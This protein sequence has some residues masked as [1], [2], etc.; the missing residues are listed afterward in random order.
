MKLFLFFATLACA[1]FISTSAPPRMPT[2]RPVRTPAGA[3]P[4]EAA[5]LPTATARGLRIPVGKGACNTSTGLTGRAGTGGTVPTAGDRAGG[6]S[7]VPTGTGSRPLSTPSPI[8]T[9]RP[10]CPRVRGISAT[11]TRPIIPMSAPARA[12]GGRCRRSNLLFPRG[13]Y[14]VLLRWTVFQIMLICISTFSGWRIY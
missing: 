12:A 9:R 2:R 11:P 3:R 10:A 6:G 14:N 8:P 7:S 13:I 5:T 1:L 4:V